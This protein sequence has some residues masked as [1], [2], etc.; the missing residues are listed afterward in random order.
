MSGCSCAPHTG[1][2]CVR[3]TILPTQ[4]K[5]LRY[6]RGVA[7][8]GCVA[9][10][11]AG[12]LIPDNLVVVDTQTL[13]LELVAGTLQG[14]V[15]VSALGG[16]IIQILGDGLFVPMPALTGVQDTSTI[17]HTLAGGILSSSVR[18]SQSCSGNQ[19]QI[20]TDGLCVPPPPVIGVTNTPTTTMQLS[21][22]IIST[23]VRISTQPGNQLTVA[24]D[25]LFV[26]APPPAPIQT[27]SDTSTVDLNVSGVT[28]TANVRISTTCPNNILTVRPDGLCVTAPNI[29]IQNV[30]NTNT[31][32]LNLTGTTLS[33]NA[34]ISPNA[35]NQLQALP[36]GLF[37][38]PPPNAL[39]LVR[40][41]GSPITSGTA[42]VTCPGDPGQANINNQTLLG[43]VGGNPYHGSVPQVGCVPTRN[44]A[45]ILVADVSGNLFRTP[46]ANV[47]TQFIG[48]VIL[49]NNT[50][51]LPGVGNGISDDLLIDSYLIPPSPVCADRFMHVNAYFN[52]GVAHSSTVAPGVVN[53]LSDGQVYIYRVS[54]GQELARAE[55]F[56]FNS[57][58]TPGLGNQNILGVGH[59]WR[60]EVD[61]AI[62]YVDI[63]TLGNETIQ[64]RIRHGFASGG[65]LQNR[66]TSAGI[67]IAV[68][69]FYYY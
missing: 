45:Q 27:V 37:V 53:G 5:P 14:N 25:G 63:I 10:Q 58:G 9:Y 46:F 16:N 7:Y 67:N 54:N 69:Q 6:V 32:A 68:L 43:F 30:Q 34:I 11:E 13:D 59:R 36:N 17:D 29:P 60:T 23:N 66:Y 39:T 26:P 50:S 52:I 24:G 41:D 33:A 56:V 42:V 3:E 31:V 2:N 12:A 61:S 21:G 57:A 8:D 44:T 18:V 49:P 20:L 35:G 51:G 1:S 48:Q 19:I 22:G 15:R 4:I 28:L 40:C 38:P 47:D 62:W 65:S 64:R 55:A